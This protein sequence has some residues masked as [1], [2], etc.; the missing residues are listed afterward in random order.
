MA[1]Y[2]RAYRVRPALQIRAGLVVFI[3]HKLSYRVVYD[4]RLLGERRKSLIERAAR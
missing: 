2:A 1:L 3:N 4:R